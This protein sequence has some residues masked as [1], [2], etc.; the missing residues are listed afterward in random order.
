MSPLTK[1]PTYQ[2]ARK[3]VEKILEQSHQIL[4]GKH[5]NYMPDW[6][7]VG[8]DSSDGLGR[9]HIKAHTEATSLRNDNLALCYLD[10]CRQSDRYRAALQK[11]LPEQDPLDAEVMCDYCT[12]SVPWDDKPHKHDADCPWLLIYGCDRVF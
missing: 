3:A 1:I 2:E 7:R 5:Q 12:A 8:S 10:V 11:L 6:L 9:D 4:S